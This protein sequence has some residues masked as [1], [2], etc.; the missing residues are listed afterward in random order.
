MKPLHL[1]CLLKDSREKL[2]TPFWEFITLGSQETENSGSLY[3]LVSRALCSQ[4]I[5]GT[6]HFS[7][8]AFQWAQFCNAAVP[9]P[10]SP[11]LHPGIS[12]SL[13]KIGK[14]PEEGMKEP[15][16]CPA[17][18]LIVFNLSIGDIRK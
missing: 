17:P 5:M 15:G 13:K 2:L 6:P 16:K 7:G 1:H 11:G 4:S 9:I 8:D 18:G 12:I 3:N 10:P 14:F